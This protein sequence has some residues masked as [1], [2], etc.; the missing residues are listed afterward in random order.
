MLDA[1]R[2]VAQQSEDGFLCVVHSHVLS[3]FRR[4]KWLLWSNG[5]HPFLKTNSFLFDDRLFQNVLAELR[6]ST[7]AKLF[8]QA[9]VVVI[10]LREPFLSSSKSYASISV[11]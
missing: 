3:K 5:Y 9:E 8:V 10:E 11:H 7:I 4:L 1:E 2:N 6:R